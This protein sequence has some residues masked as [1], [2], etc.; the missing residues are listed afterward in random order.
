[1][2][3]SQAEIAADQINQ[4]EPVKTPEPTEADLE[5]EATMLSE[6]IRGLDDESK[7]ISV[8]RKPLNTRLEAV[9]RKLTQIKIKKLKA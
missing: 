2:P 4:S 3:K 8:K 6:Q 7:A 9:V 5:K 1:M